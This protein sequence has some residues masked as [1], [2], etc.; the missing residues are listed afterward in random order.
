MSERFDKPF[1]Q[2]EP[3]PEAGIAAALRVLGHGRLHRYNTVA[4]EVAEIQTVA[5]VRDGFADKR[6]S[7]RYGAVFASLRTF[8]Q[9]MPATRAVAIPANTLEQLVTAVGGAMGKD[10]EEALTVDAASRSLLAAARIDRTKYEGVAKAG[11]LE[12]CRGLSKKVAAAGKDDWTVIEAAERAST[13][14]Q[15]LLGGAKGAQVDATVRKEAAGLG[16][17]LIAWICRQLNADVIQQAAK[18]DPKARDPYGLALA[19]GENTVLSAVKAAG[20]PVPAAVLVPAFQ[21]GTKGGDAKVVVEAGRITNEI[22]AKA[23]FELPATRFVL[24]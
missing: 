16:G 13:Q 23:P 6:S 22:L 24:K 19:A 7:V 9:V 18:S 14:F 20:L 17:D 1:T 4:G 5:F 15:G 12:V 2:Q 10:K 11:A 3:I 8:E 21:Q